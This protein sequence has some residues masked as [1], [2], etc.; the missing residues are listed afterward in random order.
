MR[1]LYVAALAAVMLVLSV[2]ARVH[3]SGAMFDRT[4]QAMITGTVTEFQWTNP[5]SS[6]KVEVTGADGKSE[7]W[8]IEMNGPNNLVRAGWKR[9][10]IKPGDK[11]TVT[12]NPLRDGRPGGWYLGIT[13][14][15]GRVLGGAGDPGTGGESA[16]SAPPPD[17][18]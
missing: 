10:T 9:S 14:A 2:P 11:V 1:S 16:A 6:F 12:I 8:S 5:H 4:Q 3:H 17:H 7:I 15:D 18:N 13:L